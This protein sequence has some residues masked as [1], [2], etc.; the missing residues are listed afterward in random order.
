M[1]ALGPGAASFQKIKIL[2][3]VL[4]SHSN[5]RIIIIER[6]VRTMT[7]YEIRDTRTNK[8][9]IRCLYIHNACK[10]MERLNRKYGEYFIMKK[11]TERK[12]YE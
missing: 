1:F 2:K 7:C 11:V 10:V 3:K 4:T 12:E 5:K 6:E 9:I 8:L